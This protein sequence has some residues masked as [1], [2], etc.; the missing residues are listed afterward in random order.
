MAET[1]P[2]V[3]E[4]VAEYLQT[5]AKLELPPAKTEV[6]PRVRKLVEQGCN[7]RFLLEASY[8]YA[9]MAHAV[10]RN[11]ETERSTASSSRLIP[12]DTLKPD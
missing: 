7:E 10:K 2:S 3:S 6:G 11:A 5:L 1:I 9:L 8:L 12:L 4:L